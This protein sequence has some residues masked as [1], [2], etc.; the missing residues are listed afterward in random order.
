MTADRRADIRARLDAATP[1]PWEAR[2][3]IHAEFTVHEVRRPGTF[4]LVASPNYGRDDYG[5]ADAELIAHAPADLAWLLDD[6]DAARATLA[7]LVADVDALADE[8]AIRS[9]PYSRDVS[10]RLGHLLAKH[11]PKED[12]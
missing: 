5:R 4:G 7:A 2:Q 12:R 10:V 11:A 1:G 6:A 3:N 8:F 9:D